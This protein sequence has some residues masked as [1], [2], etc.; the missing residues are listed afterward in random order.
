MTSLVEKFYQKHGWRIRSGPL[1]KRCPMS[2]L[3]GICLLPTLR[4][5]MGRCAIISNLCPAYWNNLDH[6][7][8]KPRLTAL[9]YRNVYCLRF[10]PIAEFCQ[11]E[12]LCGGTTKCSHATVRI[13]YY[14]GPNYPIYEF[15]QK[16]RD[17]NLNFV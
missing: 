10:C 17:N 16:I 1:A 14:K 8:M 5:A 6:P 2:Y 11:A 12:R 3:P 15:V 4:E 13:S 9:Q 7:G